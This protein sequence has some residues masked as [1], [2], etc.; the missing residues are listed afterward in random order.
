MATIRASCPDCGDVE[1]TTRDMTV[2]ICSEDGRG[3]YLFRCPS[4]TMTVTKAAE[5]RIVDLLVSS[6]VE[7]EMWSLPMELQERPVGVAL[8]HD[9]LL[10]FHEL[11]ERDDWFA[12]VVAMV[13]R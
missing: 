3:S 10:A 2:R 5:Q 6:G 11:L 1:L 4:C 7:V 12:D 8:T 9:D 13:E